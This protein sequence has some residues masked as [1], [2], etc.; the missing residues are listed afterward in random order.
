[1]LDTSLIAALRTFSHE[2]LKRFEEFLISPYFNKKKPVLKL[3]QC[4]RKFGPAFDSPRLE[5]KKVWEALFKGKE[6]NYGVMKNLIYELGKLTDKFLAVSHAEKNHFV[7]S[8]NLM[9]EQLERGLYQSFEKGL[10]LARENIA[11]NGI[12]M[13]HYSSQLKLDLLDEIYLSQEFN[14]RHYREEGTWKVIESLTKHYIISISERLYNYL[15]TSQYSSRKIEQEAVDAFLEYMQKRRKGNEDIVD[16]CRCYVILVLEP[17]NEENYS[18][19]KNIT[20]RLYEVI[21]KYF[22]NKLFMARINFCN[23]MVMNGKQ[24][25]N[26]ELFDVMKKFIY[27]GIYQGNTNDTLNQYNYAIA[28]SCACNEGEFEWAERFIEEFKDKLRPDFREQFYLYARITLNMKRKKYEEALELLTRVKQSNFMDKITVKRYQLMIYFES[29]YTNEF[30]S[31]LD[32]FSSFKN[33][34]QEL[35][36]HTRELIG[37]FIYFM[38]KIAELKFGEGDKQH[39][40]FLEDKLSKELESMRVVNKIWF[41]EKLAEMKRS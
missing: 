8:N 24:E 3:F 11:H 23:N 40:S 19:F 10:R 37:N 34:N 12:D 33:K 25:Y 36:D 4:I 39:K 26:K 7:Q 20:E 2:E 15:N 5:R 13:Y 18:D 29:C 41:N 31:M 21:S 16:L 27:D 6:F 22:R 1:L 38:K 30:Y 9:R 28:V 35:S 14:S 17:F 32:T